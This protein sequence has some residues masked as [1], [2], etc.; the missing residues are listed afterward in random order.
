MPHPCGALLAAYRGSTCALIC[1]I[2][3]SQ[4]ARYAGLVSL[5][6]YGGAYYG[7]TCVVCG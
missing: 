6:T 3:R 5:P 1:D 7:G 2:Y 4:S